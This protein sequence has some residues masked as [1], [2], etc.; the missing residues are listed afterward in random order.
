MFKLIP[1]QRWGLQGKEK[2]WLKGQSS[3]WLSESGC[4]SPITNWRPWGQRRRNIYHKNCDQVGGDWASQDRQEWGGKQ[5][6]RCWG[7]A[8]RRGG[9]VRGHC[10]N[11]E[12]IWGR[13]ESRIIR[14]STKQEWYQVNGG[15]QPIKKIRIP[16]I[17]QKQKVWYQNLPTESAGLSKRLYF[18]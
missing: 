16:M 10:R 13:I 9:W 8:A 14:K 5:Q 4:N 3:G 17:F 6:K 15:T 18:S 12:D 1:S 7:I 2:K 11:R